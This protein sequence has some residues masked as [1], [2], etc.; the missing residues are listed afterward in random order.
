MNNYLIKA[1][2]NV[3]LNMQENDLF[4]IDEDIICEAKRIAHI[5]QIK[6]IST[7]FR[8]QI[9]AGVIP[10]IVKNIVEVNNS[11]NIIKEDANNS[12]NVINNVKR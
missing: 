6:M 2:K 9:K 11:E 10:V 4:D 5:I 8:S 12:Q 7:E 3:P 1:L